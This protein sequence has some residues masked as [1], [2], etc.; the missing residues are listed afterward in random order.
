MRT[1]NKAEIEEVLRG[2][3]EYGA[4]KS[5]EFPRNHEWNYNCWGFVA[6]EH[7][8][9]STF[10]WLTAKK[11]DAILETETVHVEVPRIG[12][13]AVF[14]DLKHSNTLT[15]TVLIYAVDTNRS[16]IKVIHKPG[17][18]PLELTT[19]SDTGY[20][21]FTEYRRKEFNHAST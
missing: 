7:A 18:D 21:T 17:D 14:R 5:S 3:N 19:L 10:C 9:I 15:H 8:F 16:N 4:I 1:A 13:I 6:A 2:L 11:M 20:Y 12:D